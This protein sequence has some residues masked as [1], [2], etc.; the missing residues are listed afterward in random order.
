M[1]ET[2]QSGPA[3]KQTLRYVPHDRVDAYLALGWHLADTFDDVCH[4]RYSV[5]MVW[6]CDCQMFE[7]K[8]CR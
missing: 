2:Q 1:M 8:E 6:L 7:P 4:G 5:L 3:L